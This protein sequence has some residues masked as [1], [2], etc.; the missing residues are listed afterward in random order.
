MPPTAQGGQPRWLQCGFLSGDEDAL[1]L[2]P[3]HGHV[4]FSA[5]CGS[6][7]HDVGVSVPPE[8]ARV[9]HGGG[10]GFAVG[11]DHLG[12]VYV[13]GRCQDY[14]SASPLEN[15]GGGGSEGRVE[16][17]ADA[18][19][20]DTLNVLTRGA[21]GTPKT[22]TTTTTTP[23]A[24]AGWA[25]VAVAGESHDVRC[26]GWNG[27]GQAPSRIAVGSRVD[28]LSLAAGEHHT[29]A[30]CRDGRVW[31]WGDNSCGQLGTGR[32]QRGGGSDALEGTIAVA[33]EVPLP[34]PSVQ[35]TPGF[36]RFVAAGARHSVVVDHV[37][38]VYTF[39]WGL[40]GQCGHDD[41]EDVYV[42]TACRHLLGIPC[43]TAAAGSAHTAVVTHDGG[44]YLFGSNR[45]GELGCDG[46]AGTDD[47]ED[48]DARARY[49]VGGTSG[50]P[51]LIGF[52]CGRGDE[53]DSGGGKRVR[54]RSERA[55]ASPRVL[56]VSCGSRHTAAIVET[57]GSRGRLF[58]W[59]WNAHGQLGVGDR[60]DRA[61]PTPVSVQ[62]SS[63]DG[64]YT[65]GDVDRVSC[66][67][68]HTTVR[69]VESPPHTS[70]M[71]VSG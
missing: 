26:F 60:V 10:W 25:H 12:D 22:T 2:A 20:S 7:A 34:A 69:L 32:R 4:R 64:V 30:A 37:G 45:F 9:V 48:E 39:G 49:E 1:L 35:G 57:D 23:I 68:W 15:D 40:Y 53:G 67:W 38:V 33:A 62:G 5:P 18:T 11:S 47:E 59:G 46:G 8:Q 43:R 55:S 54:K 6:H 65:A 29:L 16:G 28:V 24:A 42:P 31:A 17:S 21:S 63:T 27:R 36:A 14:F 56:E 44:L 70:K 3:C 61:T 58:T 71:P 52:P 51:L 19:P 66:G 13:W 50:T 41:A